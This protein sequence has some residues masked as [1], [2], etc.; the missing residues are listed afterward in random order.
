MQ[1]R[2]FGSVLACLIEAAEDIVTDI[3]MDLVAMVSATVTTVVFEDMAFM[4]GMADGG[5]DRLP[6]NLQ[7]VEP[8]CPLR[9]LSSSP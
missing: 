5:A 3:T 2:R 6:R 9:Q 4:E 8:G 7:Q 1:V